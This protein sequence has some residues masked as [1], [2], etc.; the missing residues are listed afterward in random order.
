MGGDFVFILN[1]DKGIAEGIINHFLDAFYAM[2]CQHIGT[3][4]Q[5]RYGVLARQAFWSLAWALTS[6]A[7]TKWL[8]R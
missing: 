2:C 4:V 7:L 6:E 8:S 5:K 1:R 3:N